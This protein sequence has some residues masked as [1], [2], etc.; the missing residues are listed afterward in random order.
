MLN[1]NNINAK[2]FK[3]CVGNAIQQQ[4]H[5]E[6]IDV[7]NNGANLYSS[8][9]IN[10]FTD[11]WF[12]TLGKV[13]FIG[14][15]INNIGHFVLAHNI[16]DICD[17]LYN[18]EKKRI[19]F[20]GTSSDN[21]Y[22]QIEELWN[23][24]LLY[25]GNALQ[26]GGKQVEHFSE[27]VKQKAIE[28]PARFIIELAV[29]IQHNPEIVFETAGN[30][31]LDSV[32]YT[33]DSVQLMDALVNDPF[34]ESTFELA[35]EFGNNYI[36]PAAKKVAHAAKVFWNIPAKEKAQELVA[37]GIQ[38]ASVV[39]AAKLVAALPAYATMAKAS[40]LLQ[41]DKL[42]SFSDPIMEMGIS[43]E[44]QALLVLQEVDCMSEELIAVAEQAVAANVVAV[45]PAVAD[46]VSTI[47]FAVSDSITGISGGSGP[48]TP[49][50][51]P[52]E[53][54][55]IVKPLGRG[56]TGRTI[57]KNLTEQLAMKE[58]MSN[59]D[60][61]LNDGKILYR[62]IMTDPRWP[63]EEGWVKVAKNVNGVEIHYVWNEKL[64]LF[65]DF[66][67]KN[68]MPPKGSI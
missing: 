34:S 15:S 31:I 38:I 53:E 35:S 3:E 16:A 61:N 22:I 44:G 10:D 29:I 8:H 4:I 7:L 12:S 27:D 2:Q 46:A 45:S 39:G 64:N 17:G 19:N 14:S 40:L 30:L 47:A 5:Q 54:Q 26:K 43:P 66:K 68:N 49:P 67:F 63:S 9:E 25:V 62:P 59:P 55:I 6:F 24:A 20:S 11:Q 28:R 58:V 65:D 32:H 37:L 56:S 57:P 60:P 23:S 48:P 42:S 18:I 33:F 50:Q 13:S 21:E 51:I 1:Q 52:E 41:L 36:E